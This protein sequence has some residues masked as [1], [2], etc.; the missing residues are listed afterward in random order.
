MPDIVCKSFTLSETALASVTAAM[1]ELKKHYSDDPEGVLVSDFEDVIELFRLAKQTGMAVRF[2]DDGFP[3]LTVLWHW[4]G[5]GVGLSYILRDGQLRQVNLMLAG[6][7]RK[8][9]A[10][11]I[12]RFTTIL[13]QKLTNA[14]AA[15]LQP[16]GQPTL[17]T[18]TRP[19]LGSEDGSYLLGLLLFAPFSEVC[20]LS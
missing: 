15:I 2:R 17:V 3:A 11:A 4:A 12:E 10:E 14:V 6:V 20:G 18:I 19:I 13:G 1:G 8:G 16:S 5:E 7:D 9:E